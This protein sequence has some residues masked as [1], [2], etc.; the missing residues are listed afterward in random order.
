MNDLSDVR[1][2]YDSHELE[3]IHQGDLPFDLFSKW[4]KK[5]EE[6]DPRLYNAMTLATASKDGVPR[7]RTVLLK[8][9]NENGLKF[10]TNYDSHKGVD[11]ANNPKASL[12]FYWKPLERQIKIF[13]E[14]EKTTREDSE[15]YFHSRPKGSQISAFISEQSR[16]T[17]KEELLAEYKEIELKY[18]NEEIPC[19]ENWGGYIL[20][21]TQFEFW[22]G[23]SNRLHDRAEFTLENNQW[24][25]RVLAP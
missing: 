24:N 18:E 12:L 21:P 6:I 8:G 3:A 2:E 22:Q 13:G 20:K 9:Y 5:A 14:I 23:H 10:Y 15:K 7:A 1:V 4:L 17:T 19:P 16:P 25:F 11:L